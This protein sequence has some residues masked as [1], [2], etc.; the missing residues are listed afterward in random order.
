VNTMN[1]VLAAALL[2]TV[3]VQSA[4][5]EVS[6]QARSSIDRILGS[7]GTYVADDAVYKVVLPREEAT[8]VLDSQT[9]SPNL[10]LNSWAAFSSAV[11][12]EAI[13]TG[14]FLLLEDEVDD[15]LTAVLDAGLEVTGL[16]SLS[17]FQGPRLATLD[18]TAVGSFQELASAFRK[19]LNES[20][21]VRRDAIRPTKRFALPEIPLE[22]SIDP[23]P[24]N[25]ILSTRGA[26]SEGVFKAA[27]GRRTLLHGEV[28]GREMGFSSWFTFAGKNH[29]CLTHGE[30][31]VTSDELHKVLKALRV[32]KFSVASIRNHTAGEHP[33]FLFVRFWA[34]GNS[35][36]LAKG[37]RYTLDVQ[38]GAI[39][40][41]STGQ[42][43]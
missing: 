11:H 15:V 41:G 25:A 4:T 37:L 26:V 40:T 10:G 34:Q 12:H 32:K 16:A 7:K 42:K 38:F 23:G 20:R 39:A 13:L 18:I 31:V 33:Q 6:N 35:V 2:A 9:L 17:L 29:Q 27:L 28:V 8:I 3:A 24:L 36:E 21:R 5:A 22:S 1:C 43:I 30:L 14:Q 19:G